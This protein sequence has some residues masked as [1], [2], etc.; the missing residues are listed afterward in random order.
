MELN[1]WHPD[2]VA[3]QAIAVDPKIADIIIGG[4]RGLVCSEVLDDQK[5]QD[6]QT[7]TDT[8]G[9][10]AQLVVA[11]DQRGRL[12]GR[13]VTDAAALADPEVNAGKLDRDHFRIGPQSHARIDSA[14]TIFIDVSTIDRSK[15]QQEAWLNRRGRRAGSKTNDRAVG[16]IKGCAALN[17]SIESF[18]DSVNRIDNRIG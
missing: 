6:V 2:Q 15:R 13:R 3:T 8:N 12:P 9:P 18:I 4:R 11:I 1:P 7:D 17:M 10:Q 5:V 16:N 14:R